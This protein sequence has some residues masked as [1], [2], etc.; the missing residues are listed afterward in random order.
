MFCDFPK[1]KH[2]KQTIYR[3]PGGGGNATTDSEITELT[4]LSLQA[5]NSAEQAGLEA[6]AASLSAAASSNS[7][8]DSNLSA[9]AA[10]LSESAAAISASNALTSEG[11]AALSEDAAALSAAE[12]AA[13]ALSVNDSN[14]VHKTGDETIGGIKTFSSTIVGSVNG[15]AATVTTNANLTGAIT[16]VGNASSLGSFT[17]AQ[18]LAAVTDETGTGSNVFATSPTLVTPILGTPQSAT[19]TNATGLPIST[20]VSGLATGAA[21]FLTTPTSANLAAL[22]TNE[23]GTGSVVFATSPTLVTPLLGTPTSGA[24]TNCT[25]PTLNQNTTGSASTLTTGRTIAITGD[26]AYTSPAFNGSANITAAGTLATVNA[27]VGSFINASVTVNSKGLVTAA[28]SGAVGGSVTSVAATVPAF[29]SISG[30]PITTSGTL[31]ISL[32]GT[33]LPVANG[34]TGATTSTGSGAVVLGTSPTLTTPTINSAQFATVSG[35]APLYACRAWVNFNGTGTVAIRASGNVSSITD[36]GTG[37][38]TVNFTTAM[39][40]VNYSVQLTGGG[41]GGLR[42]LATVRS[43]DLL[44][45]TQVRV[46]FFEEGLGVVVDP[47]YCSFSL[48]R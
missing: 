18:L 13:S 47:P 26:L 35:T 6:D 45:T 20:G 38:Y 12:A 28:S 23:T 3:G 32:S 30:S 16:S 34:G 5:S 7:A 22:V 36:N 31:A 43:S 19:L 48:F 46:Y 21:T 2:L 24:L 44:T 17:S 14:L 42:C 9:I 40:D 11:N 29:L 1:Y 33:A 8:F 15:N 4:A 41:T 27:N 37:D 25:F 10:A 39:P